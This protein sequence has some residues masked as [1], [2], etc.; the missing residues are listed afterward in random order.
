[1]SG[2]KIEAAP[3]RNVS[4]RLY[5][6]PLLSVL[7]EIRGENGSVSTMSFAQLIEEI[8]KLSPEELDLVQ[9]KLDALQNE[10]IEE[11]PEM[12]AAIDEGLRSLREEGTIP[13][14]QVMEE[15][16]TWNFK[17]S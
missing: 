11:T 5:A 2:N 4:R 1:L 12:L 9:A 6:R 10:D 14:E 15:M 3:W 13:I 7:I 16:K 8:E 17:S